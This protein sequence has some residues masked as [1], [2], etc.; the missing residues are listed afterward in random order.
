MAPYASAFRPFLIA[1]RTKPDAW[2]SPGGRLTVVDH[3]VLSAWVARNRTGIAAAAFAG[4]KPLAC[5][6][7]AAATFSGEP[8]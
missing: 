6:P 7:Q 1:I 2:M 4:F 8:A 3:D 5:L